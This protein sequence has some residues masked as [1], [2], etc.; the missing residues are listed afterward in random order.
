[1]TG[2]TRFIDRSDRAAS[3]TFDGARETR[4]DPGSQQAGI[5]RF[6]VAP[7]NHLCAAV[8]QLLLH[9]EFV[10]RVMHDRTTSRLSRRKTY[11]GSE[12]IGRNPCGDVTQRLSVE[13]VRPATAQ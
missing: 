8:D 4:V 5:P 3:A 13:S 11:S 10:R 9:T 12:I 1:M 2:P 6:G 7:A